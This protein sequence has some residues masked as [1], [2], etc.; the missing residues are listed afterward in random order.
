MFDVNT[1][2]ARL[3]RLSLLSVIL[4]SLFVTNCSFN[5]SKPQ[6]QPVNEINV[7]AAANLTDAFTELGKEFAARTGIQVVYSF[8][9]TADLARQIEN[10]APFDVF[11]SADIENVDRLDSKGLLS[12]GTR[13]L[14]ASGRLVL[15]TPPGARVDVTSFEDLTRSDVQLIGIAKPDIAPYGRA[16]VETLKSLKLWQQLESKVIYGQNV[17]QVRQYAATGN[18]D[19]AFLPLALVQTSE[20]HVLEV[21]EQLHQSIKQAIAVVKES[22]KQEAARRFV[23]FVMSADG[24]ELLGRLGYGK[25]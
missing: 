2:S 13:T 4:L 9:A 1:F 12:E 20:G 10:N 18:V 8:G 19:V 24:Q 6:A 15:W 17:L 23:E 21:D 22:K 11:A 5:R 7:A 3:S 14:Y 25:P 16:S